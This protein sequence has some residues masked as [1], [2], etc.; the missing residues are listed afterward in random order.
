MTDDF[1]SSS[2]LTSA[3]GDFAIEK[4]IRRLIKFDRYEIEL[5]LT[6]SGIFLNVVSIKVHKDFTESIRSTS[7]PDVHDVEKYYKEE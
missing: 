3:T 7:N 6:E 2:I 4:T 1:N 5:E